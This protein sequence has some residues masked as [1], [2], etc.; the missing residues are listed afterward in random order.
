M[1]L[2]LMSE[3]LIKEVDNVYVC[4]FPQ[5]KFHSPIF[6]EQKVAVQFIH[7]KDFL[8]DFICDVD[9]TKVI[10]GKIRL[11]SNGCKNG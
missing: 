10:S 9:G 5:I 3:E 7:K 1:A 6:P 4:G 11:V 8:Y 2:N